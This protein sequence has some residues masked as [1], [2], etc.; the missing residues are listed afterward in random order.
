M[1][2]TKSSKP[3]S[4]KDI[5][6]RLRDIIELQKDQIATLKKENKEYREFILKDLAR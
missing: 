6:D 4:E 3:N 1:R 5:I 2:A